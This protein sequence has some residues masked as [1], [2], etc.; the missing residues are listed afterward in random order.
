RAPTP[1]SRARKRACCRCWSTATR[2]SRAKA[3]SPKRSTCRICADTG[4][5]GRCTYYASDLAK[6]FEVPIVH[7][8]GDDAEACVVAVWLGLAYRARFGK[9]FLIDL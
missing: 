1:M 8:N 2:R 6:G 3:S 9:D 5:A 7:V 4:P